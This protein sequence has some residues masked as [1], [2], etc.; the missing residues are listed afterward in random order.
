MSKYFIYCRKSSEEEERQA[1]S[2]E[3]QLQ[4]LREFAN[5]ENLTIVKEFIEC[6]SAKTPGREVFNEMLAALENGEADGIVAWQPDRISRNSV[7]GGKIIYLIDEGIIQDLKFPSY[8]FEK[9][10]H[11]KFNLSIAFGF[12]KMYVDRLSEDVKR[13]IREKIR[14]GEFPGLAPIGYFNHPKSR[15]I[16]PN[17][18]TFEKTKYFLE[19]FASEPISQARLR[20]EMYEAGIRSKGNH[21]L[22]YFTL[23]GMLS[24]PFYFGMFRLK[25]EIYEGSHKPMISKETFDKIQAKLT[26]NPRKVDWSRIKKTEKNFL[27]PGLARCGECGFAITQEWHK[28]KSGLVFKYYR[29]THRS[30][31]YECSQTRYLREEDLSNQVKNIISRISLSDG[32]CEKLTKM[33]KQLQ[34]EEQQS[35]QDEIL[36]LSSNLEST[37]TKL[38]R[39]LDLQLEGELELSEYK[40]KKNNLMNQKINLESQISQLLKNENQKFELVCQMLKTANEAYHSVQAEN[41]HEMNQILKKESLNPT[42]LN[43][44]LSLEFPKPLNFLSEILLQTRACRSNDLTHSL[45]S[46]RIQSPGWEGK[47]KEERQR[48]ISEGT[49]DGNWVTDS[50][51]TQAVRAEPGLL[52]ESEVSDEKW[53]A[54]LDS[55]Q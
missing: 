4:E 2:I 53:W 24:N 32:C 47:Q 12:S 48:P 46:S 54:E 43:K 41:Y 30:R 40:A 10:P 38:E 36:R 20:E 55:N 39:L 18:E 51:A 5:K 28:K 26:K 19:R 6:K 11:G 34:E 52:S 7:D 27:F 1:L 8:Y 50:E 16:E 45:V 17:P 42:L 44:K 14:R 37:K 15:T 29:C 49:G 35:S 9:S 25:G 22:N 23:R 33:A 13:G 3:S 21:K 31:S